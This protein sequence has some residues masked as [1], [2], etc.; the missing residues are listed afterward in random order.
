MQPIAPQTRPHAPDS[1]DRPF[2][3]LRQERGLRLVQDEGRGAAITDDKI[4]LFLSDPRGEP[5]AEEFMPPARAPQRRPGVVP[6]LA[7]FAAVAVAATVY[8]AMGRL[9]FSSA[10]TIDARIAPMAA[11]AATT[12]PPVAQEQRSV[13]ALVKDAAL[14]AEPPRVAEAAAGAPAPS[15]EALV[16]AYQS[17]LQSQG[18]TAPQPPQTTPAATPPAVEAAAPRETAHHLP[19]E[20][21]AALLK[22]G[23]DLIASRDV[24]AARLVLRRAAEAGDARAATRLAETYD[25][26]VLARMGVR[27]IV[28]DAA[29]ARTWYDKAAQFSAADARPAQRP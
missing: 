7:A 3:R 4:P 6:G 9:P 12:T 10:P 13:P 22:R 23:S 8:A 25:P 28:G 2:G 18:R 15:R 16:A 11:V 24:A 14:P 1:D 5:R 20:E 26:A 17:A 27:G 21:I 29:Q 19:P